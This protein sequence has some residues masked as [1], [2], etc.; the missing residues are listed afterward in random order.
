MTL[1]HS[2]EAV[3]VLTCALLSLLFWARLPSAFPTPSDEA[4]LRDRLAAQAR[5][6]E[7]VLLAPHWAERP[8]LWGLA[9]PVLNLSREATAADLARWPGRWVLSFD[10]LPRA[11]RAAAFARLERAGF[12]QAGEVETYGALSL[13]HFQSAAPREVS[14][15][16]SDA[17]E[18]AR[19]FVALEGGSVKAC[20]R[21]GDALSCLGGEGGRQSRPSLIRGET[22]EIHF[23]P[24][25]CLTLAPLGLS[26]LAIEFPDVQLGGALD[27][28][29]GPIGQANLRRERRAPLTFR[30][31]IDGERVGEWTWQPG[32][33]VE[34]R[35]TIDTRRFGEGAPHVLGFEVTGDARQPID[36]C[37]EAE[38]RR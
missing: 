37:F 30:A 28:L 5:A 18:S 34:Q 7:A 20:R 35:A 13:T 25:R 15:R 9:L 19:A 4:A 22:R 26:P 32:D 16:A 21:A 29:A 33:P 11:D 3:L 31:A 6:G 36:F 23:K 38:V 17:L 1:L 10:E 12:V 24:Y 14:F 2:L 27:L 8:R